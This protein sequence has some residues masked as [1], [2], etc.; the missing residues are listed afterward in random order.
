MKFVACIAALPQKILSIKSPWRILRQ[1]VRSD[2]ATLERVIPPD[3]FESGR[4]FNP[5]VH[6]GL[7]P[8][9]A[10]SRPEQVQQRTALFDHLV[11]ARQKRFRDFEP[12][13]LGGR[14]D[15]RRANVVS[16]KR[17][18]SD[19]SHMLCV[20]VKMRRFSGAVSGAL[21]AVSALFAGAFVPTSAAAQT[22]EPIKIGYSMAD[23]RTRPQR[24][25]RPARAEDLGGGYQCQRWAARPSG[26]AHPL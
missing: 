26:E 3:W 16:S 11:G 7:Q 24:Q 20:E 25:V 21:F 6:R 17:S 5:R 18:R 4:E 10:N 2:E 1:D 13:G 9:S 14:G 15:K 12:E 8:V 19:L 22:G 23:G